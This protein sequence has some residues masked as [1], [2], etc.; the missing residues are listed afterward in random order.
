MRA[1]D[2]VSGAISRPS[3]K[4][5]LLTLDEQKAGLLEVFKEKINKCLKKSI[6]VAGAFLALSL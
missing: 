5:Y 6:I 1:D 3:G 4:T 2:V